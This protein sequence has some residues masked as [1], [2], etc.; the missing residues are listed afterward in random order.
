MASNA[1]NSLK[2]KEDDGFIARYGRYVALTLAALG[3]LISL[4]F[5]SQMP[6]NIVIQSKLDGTT[7]GS[8][9][10]IFYLFIALVLQLGVTRGIWNAKV[11]RLKWFLAA[12]LLFI[13][14]CG[15]VAL[16]VLYV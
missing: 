10:T 12:I 16:N 14:H 8:I 1:K 13:A 5:Y 15:I 2:K 6:P 7:S 3:T 11:T 4:I 9:N